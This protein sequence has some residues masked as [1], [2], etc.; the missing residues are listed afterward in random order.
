M[1]RAHSRSIKHLTQM[2]ELSPNGTQTRRTDGTLPSAEEDIAPCLLARS[3]LLDPAPDPEIDRWTAVLRRAI[4]RVG[5]RAGGPT[6][7]GT[8]IKGLWAGDAS[9]AETTEI[10][11]GGVRRAV[12][13]RRVPAS[14]SRGARGLTSS[15][16]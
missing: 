7:D 4:G 8:L 6:R 1:R 16:R 14:H 10:P 3:G 12:R 11:A 9:E 13:H 2:H 15:R 5:G